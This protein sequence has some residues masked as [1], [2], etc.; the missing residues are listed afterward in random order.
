MSDGQDTGA[1]DSGINQILAAIGA[2][3]M[4]SMAS[5]QPVYNPPP[6]IAR[7][8]SHGMRPYTG[9]NLVDDNNNITNLTFYDTSEDYAKSVWGNLSP[10]SRESIM[11]VL[12]SKG[13]YRGDRSFGNDIDAIQNWLDYSNTLGVTSSRA[14][15]EMQKNMPNYGGG[16]GYAPRYRVSSTD[17]LKAVARQVAQQ[18]IGREFTT[19]EANRFVQAYQSAEVSAQK[20]AMGG[21]VVQDVASADVFAQQFAQQ[22]APTEA[23]GYQFLGYMNQIFNAFG[24]Q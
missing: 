4:G 22:V 2:V 24:G 18:T 16:G 8:G 1:Q 15:T 17:D 11:G 3:P 20:S 5:N 19:D 9:N 23:N 10:D 14:L 7:Q 21:G 13:F 12:K 6:R